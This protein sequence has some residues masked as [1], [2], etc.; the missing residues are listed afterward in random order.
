MR[1]GA[2]K[3]CKLK[4]LED[5]RSCFPASSVGELKLEVGGSVRL[6]I[7]LKWALEREEIRGNVLVVLDFKL[8]RQGGERGSDELNYNAGKVWR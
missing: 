2:I 5:E 7:G 4:N 6:N 1:F 8:F 3:A